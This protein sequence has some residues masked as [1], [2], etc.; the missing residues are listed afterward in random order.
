MHP[1][2]PSPQDPV[3]ARPRVAK[4]FA[5]L[6]A[7]LTAGLLL[8][9]AHS[10][11]TE[12]YEVWTDGCWPRSVGVNSDS[13][14]MRPQDFLKDILEELEPNPVSRFFLGQMRHHLLFYLL[15][16][17][18]T[19]GWAASLLLKLLLANQTAARAAFPVPTWWQMVWSFALSATAAGALFLI[20]LSASLLA[21]PRDAA[22]IP[23]ARAYLALLSG[24]AAGLFVVR[25]FAWFEGFAHRTWEGAAGALFRPGGAE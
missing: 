1:V 20:V 25:F 6:T 14:G 22:C 7:L 8:W 3:E 9:P 24:L 23:E 21:S 19:V 11:M 12:H 13:Q 15:V 5:A 4:G 2:G 16:L 18:S 10:A 17:C